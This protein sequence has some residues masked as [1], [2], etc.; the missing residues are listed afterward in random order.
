MVTTS[1]IVP[2]IPAISRFQIHKR[3]LGLEIAESLLV[4]VKS[5]SSSLLFSEV[6]YEIEI[7]AHYPAAPF[8]LVFGLV[9][10]VY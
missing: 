3:A 9:E 6:G 7:S 2:S 10:E 1:L 5:S 8:Q 4:F